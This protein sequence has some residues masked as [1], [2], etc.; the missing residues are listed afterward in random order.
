MDQYLEDIRNTDYASDYSDDSWVAAFCLLV[1]DMATMCA[2]AM[3]LWLS[4]TIS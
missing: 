4:L 1:E 2:C 3:L